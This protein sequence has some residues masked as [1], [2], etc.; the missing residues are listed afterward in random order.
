MALE[1][2][3]SFFRDP[4]GVSGTMP[5]TADA[6]EGSGETAEA[7]DPDEEADDPVDAAETEDADAAE[8]DAESPP[9]F[10]ETDD[11][12]TSPRSDTPDDL[13]ADDPEDVPEAGVTSVPEDPAGF[14]C[15]D[16]FFSPE[17]NNLLKKDFLAG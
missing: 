10:S 7:E 5:L 8:E 14:S 1:K 9:D 11:V 2:K 13:S 12:I 15:F 6:F 4:A 16:S 3:P 17:P